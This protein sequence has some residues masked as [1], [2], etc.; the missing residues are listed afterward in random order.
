MGPDKMHPMGEVDE[1]AKP[2]L[3]FQKPKVPTNW[4]VK[5]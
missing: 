1:V 4:K 2:L 3:I 5:T